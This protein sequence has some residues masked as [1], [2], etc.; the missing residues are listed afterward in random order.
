[1]FLVYHLVGLEDL[2]YV[3][4]GWAKLDAMHLIEDF[5]LLALDF[6]ALGLADGC[7]TV[8]KFAEWDVAVVDVNDHHHC[9]VVTKSGLGDVEDVDIVFC[10]ISAYGGDDTNGIL[11]YYGYDCAVH[12]SDY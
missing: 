2:G 11:A 1:M 8:T 7:E 9:K 5:F 10:K 3:D 6:Q 12:R 4:H